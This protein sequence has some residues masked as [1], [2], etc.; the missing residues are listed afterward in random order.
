MQTL[1][2]YLH[3]LEKSLDVGNLHICLGECCKYTRNSLFPLDKERD[4]NCNGFSHQVKL[5]AAGR[6]KVAERGLRDCDGA[7]EAHTT[8]PSLSLAR[9]AEFTVGVAGCLNMSSLHTHMQNRWQKEHRRLTVSSDCSCPGRVKGQVNPFSLANQWAK[10]MAQWVNR[11]LSKP[12]SVSSV[13]VTHVEGERENSHHTAMDLVPLT[14]RHSGMHTHTCIHR[15]RKSRLQMLLGYIF[16]DLYM[17]W[18][19]QFLKRSGL[20]VTPK[21]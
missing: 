6:T 13:P 7:C 17:G 1:M 10:V 3:R 8:C 16:K 20:K 12:G 19:L 5:N 2:W 21:F 15:K 4:I 11:L 18:L 14:S 9:A